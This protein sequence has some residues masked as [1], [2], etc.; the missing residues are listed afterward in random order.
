LITFPA[1]AIDALAFSLTHYLYKSKNSSMDRSK[2]TTREL[3]L[4]LAPLFADDVV[5]K[6]SGE[7]GL[8]I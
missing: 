5:V 2:N 6:E 7:E 8:F 4:L 1:V 3:L